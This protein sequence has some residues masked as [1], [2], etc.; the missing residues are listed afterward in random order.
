MPSRCLAEG[1]QRVEQPDDVS[2]DERLLGDRQREQPDQQRPGGQHAA[3]AAEPAGDRGQLGLE[4][5]AETGGVDD[6]L[7]PAHGGGVDA[8]AHARR[9]GH[10]PLRRVRRGVAVASSRSGMAGAG[11]GCPSSARPAGA[12]GP[13]MPRT[14]A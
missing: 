12:N 2:Q 11:H 4:P 5:G 14:C 13:V 3:A 6:A 9:A 1:V 8:Q 7:E 10:R